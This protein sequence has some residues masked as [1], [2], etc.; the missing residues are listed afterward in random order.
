MAVKSDPLVSGPAAEHLVSHHVDQ[1][2]QIAVGGQ[3]GVG[4]HDQVAEPGDIVDIM[5]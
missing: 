3:H 5:K 1:E 2:V 4:D